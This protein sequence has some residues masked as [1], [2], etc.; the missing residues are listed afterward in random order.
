M[1]LPALILCA[2]SF[3]AAVPA[4]FSS[5]RINIQV[6]F[7]EKSSAIQ[8]LASLPDN[9][10]LEAVIGDGFSVQPIGVKLPLPEQFLETGK[11]SYFSLKEDKLIMNV[12]YFGDLAVGRIPGRGSPPLLWTYSDKLM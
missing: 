12:Q 1:Y 9:F 2:A 6:S 3:V 11:V 5:Q 10:T 8:P 4:E 7:E